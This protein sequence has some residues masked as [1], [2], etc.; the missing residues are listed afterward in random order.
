MKYL[1][2][3]V[4]L[5]LSIL[6]APLFVFVLGSL[7]VLLTKGYAA[8]LHWYIHL[9]REGRI[10]EAF[11]WSWWIFLKP[12]IILSTL[13]TLTWISKRALVRRLQRSA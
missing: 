9:S 12:W 7:F 11:S 10:W 3:S 5:L 1:L 6:L 8:L 2:V 13:A 4:R